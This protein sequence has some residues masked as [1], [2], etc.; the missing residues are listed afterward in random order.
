LFDCFE[1]LG[2]FIKA[3]MVLEYSKIYSGFSFAIGSGWM[4]VTAFPQQ[5]H[6]KSGKGLG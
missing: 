6:K 2:D 3:P 5:S 1:V 4:T